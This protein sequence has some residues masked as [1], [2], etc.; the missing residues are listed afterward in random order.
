[1]GP[2]MLVCGIGSNPVTRSAVG[3]IR[4]PTASWKP[5]LPCAT[6][7]I[8]RDPMDKGGRFRFALAES[9]AIAPMLA[10]DTT[11]A[12]R[13]GAC[14]SRAGAGIVRPFEGSQLMPRFCRPVFLIVAV[15]VWFTPGVGRAQEKAAEHRNGV[16]VAVS[17]AGADVGVAILKQGG[18]AADA[19]IAT[20]FAM[21]V[22]YPA[23]G[24]IGGGG[25]MLVHPAP[26]K[27]EPVVFEYRETAPA[28]ATRDMFKPGASLHGHRAVGVPGTV[29]GLALADRKSV[30]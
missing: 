12:K 13:T 6:E 15:S 29:R 23:A 10:R 21:A 1:M 22:T 24:N 25:F 18:N 28:A 11:C 17:P 8:V 4:Y 16:V 30:V 2:S 5:P 20:A 27:G 19:A 7:H 14:C 26:G 3:R 9:V